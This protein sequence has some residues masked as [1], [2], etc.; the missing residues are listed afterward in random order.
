MAQVPFTLCA[1]T[2]GLDLVNQSL[3]TLTAA[4]MAMTA[5]QAGSMLPGAVCLWILDA[6]R[7]CATTIWTLGNH[8]YSLSRPAKTGELSP[9][10]VPSE[11]SLYPLSCHVQT[12]LLFSWTPAAFWFVAYQLINHQARHAAP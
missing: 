8:L 10:K 11:L 1:F 6:L 9:S 5:I 3:T 12:R 4:P 7:F 2:V